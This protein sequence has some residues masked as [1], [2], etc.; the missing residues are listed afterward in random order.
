[1]FN[2]YLQR[3][4]FFSFFIYLV[5]P[6]FIH[7][8]K[9]VDIQIKLLLVKSFVW[10][11][12]V[13]FLPFLFVKASIL[14]ILCQIPIRIVPQIRS[15]SPKILRT[16]FQPGFMIFRVSCNAVATVH[17]LWKIFVAFLRFFSAFFLQHHLSS[18]IVLRRDKGE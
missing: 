11:F 10:T 1:M 17:S 16:C 8:W 12:F 18:D 14:I 4:L 7:I 3:L 9:L 5:W 6:F 2:Q 13:P 15:K